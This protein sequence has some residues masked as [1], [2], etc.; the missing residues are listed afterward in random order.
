ME[1]RKSVKGKQAKPKK[2]LGKSKMIGSKKLS[3][4]F[5][6][7]N[8]LIKKMQDRLKKLK[9]DGPKYMKN[10]NKGGALQKTSPSQKGLKKLSTSVRNK[11]GYMSKGGMASNK[12]KK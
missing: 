1:M 10:M 12:G 7:H 11:M 9:E 8:A 2:A 4:S 6:K 3:R 5:S